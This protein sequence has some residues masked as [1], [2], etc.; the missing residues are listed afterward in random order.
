MGRPSVRGVHGKVK[1][2]R[3]Y[4]DVGEEMHYMCGA[5]ENGGDQYYVTRSFDH[6]GV[7]FACVQSEGRGRLAGPR[8]LLLEPSPSSMLPLTPSPLH[9]FSLSP[10]P[11]PLHPFPPSAACLFLFLPGGRPFQ[12]RL[13]CYL[14]SSA[15][16]LRGNFKIF[17]LRRLLLFSPLQ[18]T[19][20]DQQLH[21][22]NSSPLPLSPGS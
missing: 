6:D 9:P 12:T 21:P 4:Y 3:H 20:R 10:S 2:H 15:W 7:M 13:A 22:P 11:L 17:E 14:W 5:T 18:P 8:L 16:A 19:P 1:L